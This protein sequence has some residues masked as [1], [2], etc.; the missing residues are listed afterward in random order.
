MRRDRRAAYRHGLSAEVSAAALLMAKGY[1]LLARRYKTR[2]LTADFQAG[3]IALFGMATMHG[4]L[5]NC[6]P[7]GR[8]RVSCDVRYQ[9]AA[10]PRDERYYGPNP[11]GTTGIGYAELNGAKPLTEDWH[12]R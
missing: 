6:S 7:I 11:A 2:L 9:P 1:R 12:T 3:D 4:S 5:D 10:D 8:V